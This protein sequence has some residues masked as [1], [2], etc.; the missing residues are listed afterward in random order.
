MQLN[1]IDS[2]NGVDYIRLYLAVAEFSRKERRYREPDFSVYSKRDFIKKFFGEECG[3]WVI[4][5]FLIFL[6]VNYYILYI[7][8]KVFTISQ[9]ELECNNTIVTVILY[10]D[11]EVYRNKHFV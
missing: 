8:T 5:I 10:I 9:S 4:F 3:L 11:C 2:L 1:Q 6:N 7:Y